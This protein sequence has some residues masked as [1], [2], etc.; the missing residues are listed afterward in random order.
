M[1]L[2]AFRN[3]RTA[4]RPVGWLVALALGLAGFALNLLEVQLGWGLHFI[5]GNALIFA[6]LRGLRPGP[7]V[8]A[9]ALSS[10]RSVLLWGHP[11][12]WLI[13]TIEAAVLARFARRT[14]PIRV[15][16]LFWIFLGA[17]LLALTYGGILDMDRISL[18]LVI[19]KQAVN[20]VL[21]V[22]LGEALYLAFLAVSARRSRLRWPAVSFEAA[23][24]MVLMLTIL[25]P[26]ITYLAVD[27]PNREREA[28]A[29]VARGLQDSLFVSGTQLDAWRDSRGLLLAGLAAERAMNGAL[30]G[31]L[32]DT[33]AQ[34]LREFETITAFAPDGRQ[35]WQLV[36]SGS[37]PLAR[38]ARGVRATGPG[39]QPAMQPVN[40]PAVPAGVA[41]VVPLQG[42][43]AGGRIVAIA[44]REQ[45]L[46]IAGDRHRQ[47]DEGLY[48][49]APDD[50]WIDL[51]Q[52]DPA[53]RSRVE[54]LAPEVL[55]AADR[56][57]ALAA[58]SG[59]G[60]SLMSD[61][62]NALLLRID[63][64]PDQP[65]WRMLA[66]QPLRVEVLR[67]RQAQVQMLLILVALV[68]LVMVL[69]TVLAVRFQLSLRRIARATA[70][71]ALTGARPERLD[72]LVIRELSDISVSLATTDSE[73]AR[74]RGALIAYQR[75]LQSIAAHAPVVVYALGRLGTNEDRLLY[76][77]EGLEK[78]LGHRPS[79]AMTRG[80]LLRK[81]HPDDRERY[82]A[83]I[84]QLE[85]GRSFELEYRIRHRLGHWVWI[86]DTL[87]L[88]AD[89][90]FG[91][92]EAVGLMIDVTDRKA[93]AEQLIQADKMAGLG[94]MVAGIAH[95]LNQPLNF[96]QLAVTN[97]SARAR[98]GMID[99]E[100]L[101]EK[102][103]QVLAYVGRAA[104]IIQQMRVFGRPQSEP[105][106]AVRLDEAIGAVL[107][108]VRPQ[109]AGNGI[110]VD[111]AGVAPGLAVLAQPNLLE[112]VLVNL[113]L[114]AQDAIRTRLARDGGD[115]G[116][117]VLAASAQG[118][119]V[120]LTVDDNGTGIAPEAA[121]MLFEPFFT[122]KPPREGMGLGLSISYEIVHD[123]G[124][125]IS[126]ENTAQGARLTVRLAAA[127]AG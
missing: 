68:V 114:N 26:T 84:A 92:A 91:R 93:A 86:Y 71:L 88:A 34:L 42:Q 108:M 82:K 18:L 115:P 66:V 16:V 33:R 21:N 50:S 101:A 35:L 1:L 61:L 31:M 80:W 112:Q 14:S 64:L 124:G 23:V 3:L 15:D 56:D 123:L 95:E 39:D 107:T 4:V 94:R 98:R 121:A 119:R 41:L 78:T 40:D 32:G 20:A 99:A 17:P 57:A 109:L 53:V 46:R 27:A 45:L 102:L 36:R 81:I 79:D 55:A 127:P 11:W 60:N 77:S 54:R 69:G 67:A 6:F 85:P 89:P 90:V 75:R 30:P 117:I 100:R 70:D 9:A 13:W 44:R 118:D 105:P 97:L 76:V 2:T 122:T 116:R 113:L 87:A 58:A 110:T 24:H 96:I 74:E 7:L 8:F 49:I 72:R 10:G 73:F 19:G 25:V 5:F 104:L 51:G 37:E 12:S 59:Y 48:L 29:S 47:A 28:R 43:L 38:L 22:A 111:T 103:D 120:V 62:R 106:R 63:P 52:S 126:A 125:E 65:G 83:V